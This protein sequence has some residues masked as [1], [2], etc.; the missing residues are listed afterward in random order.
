[1]SH[2]NLSG[3]WNGMYSYPRGFGPGQFSATLCDGG[4]VLSGE[5]VEIANAGRATGRTLHGLI[6]GRHEGAS[7]TFTKVYDD[8]H[9]RLI[10]YSGTVNDDGTEIA[11]RWDIPNVWGGSF[12]MVRASGTLERTIAR[13]TI[14]V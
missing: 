4:G 8:Y 5:T 10:R 1:M 11:G 13:E 2:S 3:A 6:S 9:Q 7:V 12:I 14:S